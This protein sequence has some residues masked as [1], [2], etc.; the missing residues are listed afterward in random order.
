LGNLK[1]SLIKKKIKR[2]YLKK[3]KIVKKVIKNQEI[4]AHEK[5]SF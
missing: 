1:K 2:K 3:M 5:A 4:M